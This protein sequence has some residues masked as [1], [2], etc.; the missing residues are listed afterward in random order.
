MP[1]SN[2]VCT[3]N[4][5]DDVG[6]AY[7]FR[8]GRAASFKHLERGAGNKSPKTTLMT[9]TT[10]TQKRRDI[11]DDV[12][13][14]P[15]ASASSSSKE[16]KKNPNW[17]KRA[18]KWQDDDVDV[19]W[20]ELPGQLIFDPLL[21][22]A[23]ADGDPPS[24]LPRNNNLAQ[25]LLIGAVPVLLVHHCQFYFII[26]VIV[27][28]WRRR[29]GRRAALV[30]K[31]FIQQLWGRADCLVVFNSTFNSIASRRVAVASLLMRS[32]YATP[33]S[34]SFTKLLLRSSIFD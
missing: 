27:I 19:F 24:L 22:S 6:V 8:L 32:D 23:A 20:E 17:E 9:T 18:R 26:I 33:S 12:L 21:C 5:V 15:T 3:R 4:D 31:V 1:S 13:G 34:F 10:S 28:T 11:K 14:P 29:F 16:E 25:R 2:L 7:R 30:G